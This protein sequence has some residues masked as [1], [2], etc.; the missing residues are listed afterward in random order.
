MA[1]E[2]EGYETDWSGYNISAFVANHTCPVGASGMLVFYCGNQNT[3]AR[4]VSVIWNSV[5][6]TQLWDSG[7]TNNAKCYYLDGP[8]EGA[9]QLI[10]YLNTS[11]NWH[12]SFCVWLSG[13]KPGD[14]IGDTDFGG[15]PRSVTPTSLQDIV[16]SCGSSYNDSNPVVS[17]GDL[18]QWAVYQ[19]DMCLGYK[20]ATTSAVSCSYANATNVSGVV[21]KGVAGGPTAI[22]MF[23]KS[24]QDFMDR[25]RQGLI[26]QNQLKKEYGRVMNMHP[27]P[28][29]VLKIDKVGSYANN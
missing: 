14:M 5:G 2:R 20:E 21:V 6:L 22:A 24:Y 4:P 8:D 29:K 25:L 15:N 12:E 19:N 11:Q 26:P 7:G 17:G 16:I 9:H 1:T 27:Q 18:T 3:T 10:M 13:S 23:Y 28:V